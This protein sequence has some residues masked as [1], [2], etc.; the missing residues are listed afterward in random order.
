MQRFNIVSGENKA[1]LTYPAGDNNG[2][3]ACRGI[4]VTFPPHSSCPHLNNIKTH[5]VSSSQNFCHLTYDTI[6][7]T[8]PQTITNLCSDGPHTVGQ[9]TSIAYNVIT[10]NEFHGNQTSSQRP[11][12]LKMATTSNSP[13]VLAN[14]VTEVEAIRPGDSNI[15]IPVP[16][17]TG[18]HHWVLLFIYKLVKR[19]S[20][21]SRLRQRLNHD[22]IK[23][24][25]GLLAAKVRSCKLLVKRTWLT[26]CLKDGII[27]TFI[28][29]KLHTPSTAMAKKL[30]C[31]KIN[32]L[33]CCLQNC[34]HQI[35]CFNTTL[36]KLDF[37]S[38]A[39]FM[40]YCL[41]LCNKTKVATRVKVSMFTNEFP[42]YDADY[43]S[44]LVNN[45]TNLST[46]H[47]SE[48]EKFALKFGLKFCIPPRKINA[49]HLKAQFESL[50]NQLCDLTAI[51][52][53]NDALLRSRLV[54]L[55]NEIVKTKY[56]TTLCPLSMFHLNALKTLTRNKDLIICRPDKGNGVVIL[57][58]TDYI[59]KMKL[60]LG[61]QQ[62]FIIDAKQEDTSMKT[63]E[64]IKKLVKSMVVKGFIS[65]ELANKLTPT[66]CTIPRMYGL[67]K[68]HKSGVPLRPILSMINSPQHLL[69][70]FLAHVLKPV[71]NYYCKYQII[72]SFDLVSKLA[73][74]DRAPNTECCLGSLDI[75]SLFTS[76]PVQKCITI[77]KEVAQLDEVD[78][79]FSAEAIGLLI[80][81]CVTN[82]QMLFN[83]TYY[84]QIDGVAMG[85]PL[86]PVLA[87]IYVG[88]IEQS[89]SD[90]D[91]DVFFFGR[92]VDDV[93]VVA[94]DALT[95]THLRDRFNT[96]DCNI[97]FTAELESEGSIPFLDIRI[98]KGKDGLRFAWHHKN[99]W[100][101]SLLHFNSFVPMSWK[102]GL[103]IGF[104]TRILRLCSPEFIQSALDELNNVFQTNGYPH[105]FIDRWF[106]NYLPCPK[107]NTINTVRRKPVSIYLP[108]MGDCISSQISL[109][110]NRY[111]QSAY[112]TAHVTVRWQPTKACH[113]SLKDK[114]PTLNIPRVVYHFQCPCI[115]ANYVGRTELPLGERVRQHL[116]RWLL[117]GKKQRPRS[118]NKPQS[119]ICRHRLQCHTQSGNLESAFK[120]IHTAQT[121]FLLKILEAL[122]IKIKKP[123]LC[124]QKDNLFELKIPWF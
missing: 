93:L 35:V 115:Q 82:V 31:D 2:P 77:I 92:Y 14:L 80:E 7:E 46:Y 79:Q 84:R 11:N 5:L 87:N 98:H 26:N 107:P 15:P 81:A 19:K 55:S 114:L 21:F 64:H 52:P 23:K 102:T 54:L 105:P 124:I 65:E 63:L 97:Q 3:C 101:G 1:S 94:R 123:N 71:V 119:A 57:N 4:N 30:M 36:N 90:I 61:D 104:K 13:A 117:Q 40:K 120:I 28:I 108:F 83:G 73:H 67:P 88:Y 68:T 66:G 25:D 18:V 59:D 29:N 43:D 70:K 53:L 74:I 32:D 22:I 91:R 85:S 78:I 109:R 42:H 17:R 113:V 103:L 9:T 24:L 118:N 75:V 34:Q 51:G 10:S 62:R 58:R 27:P 112:P 106:I 110:L 33:N 8:A 39:I 56:S 48:T 38:F 76:V 121:P 69:A 49:T 72:D 99:T 96:V 16:R 122:E 20:A 116:P 41:Y 37:Y 12:I 86:G 44:K 60:I 50:Y 95:I 6:D 100:T 45:I 89:V 111:V 47:L